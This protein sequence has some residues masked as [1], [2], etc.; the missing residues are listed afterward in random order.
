MHI[1]SSKKGYVRPLFGMS[2]TKREWSL[3]RFGVSYDFVYAAKIVF[4]S[5]ISGRNL[6]KVS[7]LGSNHLVL[8]V[9][10]TSFCN[11]DQAKSWP[12]SS[13]LRGRRR[14]YHTIIK[15]ADHALFKMVIL[16]CIT[17]S[18]SCWQP[19]AGDTKLANTAVF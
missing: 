9:A 4:K 5:H 7:N 12:S 8:V 14:T 6:K 3:Y 1:I 2:G 16:T 17:K 11:D 10:T 19:M 13:G 18:L 15:L